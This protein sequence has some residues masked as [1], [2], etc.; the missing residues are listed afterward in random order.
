MSFKS[1]LTSKLATLEAARTI[2]FIVVGLGIKES[3]GIFSLSS[4]I[5]PTNWHWIT[6]F[7]VGAGYLFTA[8]RFIHGVSM[9]HGHEKWRLENSNLPSSKRILTSAFFIILMAVSLYLMA[10]NITNFQRYVCFTAT[11]LL[12][13]LCLIHFTE[14]IS[15]TFSFETLFRGWERTTDGYHARAALQWLW[16]DI[17]LL[18]LA[19][20]LMVYSYNGFGIYL[21]NYYGLNVPLIPIE[22]YWGGIL[23]AAGIFDYYINRAFYFGSKGDRQNQ[24]FIFVCSPLSKELT[25][26]DEKTDELSK[27]I[28]LAQYY[29]KKLTEDHNLTPYAS[30]SFYTYFLD[31][32]KEK[33]RSIGRQCALA[34]LAACD[35]MYVYVP[36]IK[37]RETELSRGMKH[38]LREAKKLGLQIEYKQ[39]ETILPSGWKST[40]R[41]LEWNTPEEEHSI[42]IKN[43]G[44]SFQ[45]K[46]QTQNGGVRKNSVEFEGAVLRKRVYVCTNLR[47]RPLSIDEIL[48]EK[49]AQLYEKLTEEEKKQSEIVNK[50][51][52]EETQKQQAALKLKERMEAN[53]K[54]ALWQCH[55]LATD[56]KTFL[57]HFAPQSFFTYFWYIKIDVKKENGKWLMIESESWSQW[58]E[59]ALEVLKVCDAVYIYSED[60]LPDSENLSEGM[61]KVYELAERLGIE[62]KYRQEKAVETGWNPASPDFQIE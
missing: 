23:V 28:N 20:F 57:A 29:C 17:I 54:N 27:N 40:W 6:F 1:K 36:D 31:D 33:D 24:K 34:Y 49:Q 7:I 51:I 9:Y 48:T 37:K 60:G 14:A 11:M 53:V 8:I 55:D 4:S 58:F 16:S 38:E 52:P 61:R 35:A 42:V 46:Y 22:A 2:F 19:N 45:L 21:L 39:A 44:K 15:N 47:G 56:D 41:S 12:V 50:I 62:I 43:G 26:E 32:A 59:K 10:I 5:R 18:I 13:D 3:L 25:S 30:H